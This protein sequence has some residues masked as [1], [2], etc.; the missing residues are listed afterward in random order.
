[1][2][3]WQSRSAMRERDHRISL[4]PLVST[5][6]PS[7]WQRNPPRLRNSRIADPEREKPRAGFHPDRQ[8]LFIRR[9]MRVFWRV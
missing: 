5:P 2:M 4:M 9:L 6:E 7:F 3:H 8:P 1:M